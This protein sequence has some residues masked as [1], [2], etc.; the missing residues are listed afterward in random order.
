MAIYDLYPYNSF[1]V[2]YLNASHYREHQ[3]VGF[4]GMIDE[5]HN[6]GLSYRVNGVIHKHK[7]GIVRTEIKGIFSQNTFGLSGI[8]KI[9]I[10]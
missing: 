10:Y 5:I 9:S 3:N 7:S 4:N 2:R 1:H 8:I 6:T